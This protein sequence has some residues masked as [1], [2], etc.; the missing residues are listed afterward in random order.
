MNEKTEVICMLSG[1]MNNN[2]Q[3]CQLLVEPIKGKKC[4]FFKTAVDNQMEC[5]RLGVQSWQEI[6]INCRDK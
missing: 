4:P 1:C 6:E 2:G 3:V 5:I